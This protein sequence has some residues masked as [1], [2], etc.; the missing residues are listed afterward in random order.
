V[1]PSSKSLADH[2]FPGVIDG[3][4]GSLIVN[5]ETLEVYGHVVASNP[6]GEAY[7]V[8][9]RATFDQI[10][11]ALGAKELS[12]P[13]PG[14]LMANLVAH[15]S[16]AGDADAA[17]EVKLVLASMVAEEPFDVETSPQLAVKDG[18]A[19][20]I[21]IAGHDNLS[22]REAARPLREKGEGAN[23]DA[24]EDC[25]KTSHL[26]AEDGGDAFGQML[27]EKIVKRQ[28][29][30]PSGNSAI[31]SSASFTPQTNTRRSRHSST[32]DLPVE[33]QDP[34]EASSS[35]TMTTQRSGMPI[36]ENPRSSLNTSEPGFGSQKGEYDEQWAKDLRPQFEQLLRTKRLN[37]LDRP[38]SR[39]DSPSPRERASTQQGGTPVRKISPLFL[40]TSRPEFVSQNLEYD[41]QW[42]KDLRVQFEALLRTKRLNELDQS[43][44]R[45]D[46]PSPRERASSSSLRES[47]SSSLNPP[48]STPSTPSYASPRNLPK[49][50]S[51]P[52]DALSQ[53]FRKLLISLSLTPT[54]YE[55]PGL[56]DEALQVIPLDRIYGEAEDESQELQAQ[57]ESMGDG[58]KPEWGYQDCVIRALLRYVAINCHNFR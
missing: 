38:R 2:I 27:V 10:G 39:T 23:I 13:S 29:V 55:N 19:K 41:E 58:R 18:N 12:L 54:K 53:K 52:A 57:A 31:R 43:R 9:L 50:P 26:A 48:P 24:Q 25:E 33:I 36:R 30:T 15:Y 51:P 42:A 35:R 28:D 46:S 16:E 11:D 3:D 8:P 5:Q 20:A 7:V 45:T 14:P 47:A 34:T 56:L 1:N 22:A 49:I 21:E 40:N 44:S 17:N 6:L 32:Q 4:C 37:E